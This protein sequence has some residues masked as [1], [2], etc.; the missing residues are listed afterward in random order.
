MWFLL[1]Q[2]YGCQSF[3]VLFFKKEQLQPVRG[4]PND[5]HARPWGARIVY[6]WGVLHCARALPALRQAHAALL[7][8]L[9]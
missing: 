1:C 9:V 3:L 5:R 7:A 6:A 4:R 2:V 8:V